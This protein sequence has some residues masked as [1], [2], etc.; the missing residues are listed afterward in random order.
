[1]NITCIFF[2]VIFTIVGFLFAA[3]KIHPHIP[4]WKQMPAEEKKKIRIGPLCRNIGE[5]ILLSG[6]IFLLKGV[7]PAFTDHWFTG[8]MIAWLIVA[9]L[10]VWFI[11][12]NRKFQST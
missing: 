9:G 6:I 3:G 11:T 7:C 5:I 4:A 10:D 8:S 1:M 2:G 12:K